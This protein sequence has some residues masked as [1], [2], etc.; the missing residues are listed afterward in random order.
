MLQPISII[1]GLRPRKLYT[2]VAV[3][4]V[5]VRV[6]TQ[7]PLVQSYTSVVGKGYNSSS[8]P[9]TSLLFDEVNNVGDTDKLKIFICLHSQKDL[10]RWIRRYHNNCPSNGGKEGLLYDI[11]NA[12]YLNRFKVII[13]C[14]S[15]LSKITHTHIYYNFWV[16]IPHS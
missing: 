1:H 5:P 12:D 11:L 14:H 3:T 4:P 9:R 7:W 15:V 16:W 13:R 8:C 2:T 10:Y 6:P